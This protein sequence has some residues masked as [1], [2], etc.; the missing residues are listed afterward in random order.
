MPRKTKAELAEEERQAAL[1]AAG[2]DPVDEADSKSDPERVAAE[3]AKANETYSGEGRNVV[4]A[5]NEGAIG[6]GAGGVLPASTPTTG[7]VT[8][9]SATGTTGTNNTGSV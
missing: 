1:L 2:A 6:D 9:S 4:P 8:S 3:T 7:D 5:H